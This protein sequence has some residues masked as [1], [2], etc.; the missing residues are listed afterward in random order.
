MG[1]VRDLPSSSEEIPEAY[2]DQEWAR[3]G[4]NVA[5]DFEPLYVIPDEKK[6]VVRDLKEALKGA[7][8][9]IVA[10][11]EDRE[12]E[13]IGWHLV[14]VLKPKVPVRR[15]VFHEI[16]RSAIEDAI[17][18]YRAIDLELVHAQ[19]T[20]RILDRLVGY[21]V[22]PL[23]WK[24]IK[25]G[26]SAGRVQSVAVRLLVN[27]EEDRR[28]FHS[29]IYWD[30]RAMLSPAHQVGA[31]P[32]KSRFEATLQSVGSRRVAT[33][34]DFD[35]AT[36]QIA[37]SKAKQILL[38]DEAQA[39][40]LRQRLLKA[41]WRVTDLNERSQ[42]RKPAPPFTTST[43]QQE[44]NRKLRLP[45]RQTMNVAQKLYENGYI[46]YMRI[47]SV[48][49]SSEA[50]GAARRTIEQRYG[51]DYL[52][53]VPRQYTTQ[54]KGA[55]EAHEA[56]RPAGVE[57]RTADEIGLTGSEAAL[58]D[59]IWKRTVATQMA[60]AQLTLITVL[61]SVADAVFQASGKRIDFPGFFRAYVEGSD[62]PDAALEDR[63]VVLPPLKSGDPLKCH[64]LDAVG[65]ETQPPNRY[66]EASLVQ[67]LEREGVGRPSTYA[68]IISTIQERGYVVKTNNQLV[69][70]FTA[71]AVNRLLEGHFSDLVDTQFTARMEQ[72]LDDIS[73]GKEEWLPY[74]RNFYLG[75]SGLEAQVEQKTQSIDPR[76][77]YAL[78]LDDIQ[79]RV[80]VGRYGPYLEQQCEGEPLRVSLPA[81]FP[82]GDLVPDEAVRLLQQK[83]EGPDVLGHH[84]ETGKPIFVLSGR[85]GPYVQLG[86]ADNNGNKPRRASL[87]KGMKPEDVTLDVA[88]ALLQLPRSLGTHPETN[89]VIEA[90][91]GR[92]GP[93]VRHGDDYRSLTATDN[94]LTVDLDRALELLSQPKAGR[95]MR[96]PAEPLRE[97]GVHPADSQPVVLMSGQYGPYVKHGEVN[98]TLPRG[99][100]P[101]SVTLDQAIA[102][103][104]AKAANPT[105]KRKRTTARA[106][107]STTTTAKTA[108]A[109]TTKSSGSASTAKKA[110]TPKPA[111]ATP[112]KPKSSTRKSKPTR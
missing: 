25:P 70:T 84:P 15:M 55:Q 67:T 80:R 96:K 11:D 23:L 30:L 107:K 39:Q 6:K 74:L 48:H 68:T 36:G 17:K 63:E 61:I 37:A 93:Y 97:I 71:F 105:T 45:A 26:L 34:K 5:A 56:I 40:E 3:I 83:E 41:A 44:A 20:R 110:A 43:L 82:P 112:A 4:I 49:L 99:T 64:E 86:E 16:T 72:A 1:H 65:H 54:S 94:V 51:K 104:A 27:R 46:T 90:N 52:S 21:T 59:L 91:V 24:K 9:L 47:D 106:A 33:G 42:V 22:S 92:F 50:I 32:L 29:G 103:I 14:Q 31:A 10:T 77:I 98:A 12:G 87:L 8:E 95:G 73:E 58:Y 75:D 81:D 38:L 89:Q 35:E 62:D 66:T 18:H 100:D 28:A 53:P 109:T 85:F 79:A 88:V 60:D 102:L 69:P 13:S 78:A 19:E 7:D 76:D 108:Q 57:M 111:T 2:K 101:A